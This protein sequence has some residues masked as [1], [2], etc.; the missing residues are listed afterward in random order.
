[1]VKVAWYSSITDSVG[2]DEVCRNILPE[3]EKLGVDVYL[4]PG[5]WGAKVIVTTPWEKYV[6]YPPDDA[7]WV[8]ENIPPGWRP[9]GKYAIGYT[10]FEASR[11]PPKWMPYFGVVDEVWCPSTY[12]KK[13]FE[14][15]G[16]KKPIYLMHHGVDTNRFNPRVKPV[17][18]LNKRT[19]CFLTVISG[20][21]RRKGLD[22]LVKA[23]TSEF[24]ADEDVCLIVKFTEHASPLYKVIL[25]LINRS[26]RRSSN[27][28]KI[29][30]IK[31]VIPPED[32]PRLYRIADCYVSPSRAE[33]FNLTLLEAM[34]SGVPVIAT[35]YGGHLDYLTSKNS[36][37]VNIEKL[38]PVDSET[39]VWYDHRI[40]KWA[41]PDISHLKE[42][43]RYVYENPDIAME[44]ASRALRDV[45]RKWTWKHAAK[46]I[47]KRLKEVD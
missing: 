12:C 20:T 25:P 27:I 40:M 39:S 32:M 17:R 6:K 9:M 45:R 28:P 4:R 15:S 19:F 22:A 16:V 41:E 24:N 33:G 2:Y 43:M 11:L 30:Y 21:P 1:M 13:M 26:I 29:L 42:L 10:M 23:Y 18:I 14:E 7:I 47:Y 44:K 36:F 8:F 38:V 46:R 3:L 35:A 34:A 31:K 37:M 5:E